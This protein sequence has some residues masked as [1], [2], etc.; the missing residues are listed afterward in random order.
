MMKTILIYGL[1]FVGLAL[2]NAFG[3][4]LDILLGIG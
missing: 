3:I 1:G 2:L 4:Y